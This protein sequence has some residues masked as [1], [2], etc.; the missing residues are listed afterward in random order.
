MKEINEE[1]INEELIKAYKE[2]EIVSRY[3]VGETS[4]EF[5]KRAEKRRELQDK[6]ISLRNLKGS[7]K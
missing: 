2:L 7:L 1:K 3:G 5:I 6:I 4:E